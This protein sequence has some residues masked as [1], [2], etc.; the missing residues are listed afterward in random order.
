MEPTISRTVTA[1]QVGA[2]GG[3]EFKQQFLTQFNRLGLESLLVYVSGHTPDIAAAALRQVMASLERPRGLY[4]ASP[5][6]PAPAPVIAGLPVPP[7]PAGT[8]GRVAG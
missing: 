7:L 8:G 3:S 2:L 4:A 5:A 6:A 1:E